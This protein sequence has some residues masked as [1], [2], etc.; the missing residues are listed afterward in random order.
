MDVSRTVLP[1]TT[2]G[3]NM[4]RFISLACFEGC[5]IDQ[6]GGKG[7]VLLCIYQGASCCS[8]IS[9]SMTGNEKPHHASTGAKTG[10]ALLIS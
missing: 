2:K 8:C 1:S 6:P 3:Q 10:S 5:T 7:R 9:L 4:A